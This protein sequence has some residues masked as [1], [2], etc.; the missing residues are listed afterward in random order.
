LYYGVLHICYTL[1]LEPSYV[2]TD[3]CRYLAF[4]GWREKVGN[5]GLRD[6]FD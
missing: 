4:L 2:L 3:I 1:R 6:F 5:E